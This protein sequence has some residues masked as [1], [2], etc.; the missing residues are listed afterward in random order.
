MI[1]VLTIT[2]TQS[3]AQSECFACFFAFINLNINF[4][5][6]ENCWCY[7][8]NLL[9]IRP[10]NLDWLDRFEDQMWE[11]YRNSLSLPLSLFPF[12]F[13]SAYHSC[14]LSF[15]FSNTLFHSHS[16]T[17]PSFSRLIHS[18]SS[19]G[20]ERYSLYVRTALTLDGTNGTAVA[21]IVPTG[22]K[23]RR[24]WLQDK[25]YTGKYTDRRTKKRK[26]RHKIS[27]KWKGGKG[28]GRKKKKK[29][30]KRENFSSL[31]MSGE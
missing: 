15:L 30:E 7:Y 5:I 19:R 25:F 4:N 18:Y 10:I 3:Q 22:S 13:L 2:H 21:R 23:C 16:H 17:S 29:E 8:I 20:N 12:L 6:S 28:N 26:R 11:M 9:N 31:F 27:K 24:R 1:S 14:C